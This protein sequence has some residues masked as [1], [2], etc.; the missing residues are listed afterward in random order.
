MGFTPRIHVAR[1]DRAADKSL[2]KLDEPE[3]RISPK[4][5]CEDTEGELRYRLA[6]ALLAARP[7]RLETFKRVGQTQAAI[8]LAVMAAGGLAAYF[9][10]G[11][12]F[13]V[14]VVCIAL[15]LGGLVFTARLNTRSAREL[16]LAAIELT[17][18]PETALKILADG[19]KEAPSWMPGFLIKWG[20]RTSAR[21]I[22]YYRSEVARRGLS[23]RPPGGI[24][25]ANLMGEASEKGASNDLRSTS[26]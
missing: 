6:G 24:S 1:F 23:A 11:S 12:L 7:E 4:A 9:A 2:T 26:E 25:G 15:L 17:G 5:L 16:P 10:S 14:V 22:A 18:D 3:L 20:A 13:L 8:L 19:W 21:S